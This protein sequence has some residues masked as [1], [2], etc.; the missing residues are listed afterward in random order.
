MDWETLLKN[1]IQKIRKTVKIEVKLTHVKNHLRECEFFF[2]H[3]SIN[4]IIRTK[5]SR[6][7]TTRFFAPLPV[8]A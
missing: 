5:N 6:R 2:K 7:K 4:F 1:P 8:S 3:R